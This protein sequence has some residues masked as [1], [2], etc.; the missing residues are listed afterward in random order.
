MPHGSHDSAPRRRRPPARGWQRLVVVLIVGLRFPM[1]A[2][3]A[4]DVARPPAATARASDRIASHWSFRPVKRPSVPAT[5][6][7]SS[8]RANPIDA[9]V[10]A[11]LAETGIEPSPGA[12]RPTLIRRLYFVML[13]MAP[14]PEEVDRFVADTRP[15]AFERCVDLVLDDPR[16]GERWAR[17]WLD[18]VRFA[19]TNGFETNRERPNGWRF[20]D[21]IIAS[22]NDD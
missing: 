15:D 16:Y 5:G 12:D 4:V 17:H 6:S 10:G 8:R 13:G 22:L 9:F 3:P 1:A 19:E 21:Y 14:T 18:V 20:R 7:G 2:T 11:K